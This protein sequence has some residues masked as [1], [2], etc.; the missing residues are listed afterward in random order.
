MSLSSFDG[1][2]RSRLLVLEAVR[3]EPDAEILTGTMALI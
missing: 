3:R 1:Q 2:I